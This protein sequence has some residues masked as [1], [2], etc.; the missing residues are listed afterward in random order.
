MRTFLIFS[1]LLV[2][3]IIFAP[4]IFA[5]VL[6]GI[7]ALTVSGLV[8]LTIVAA[9]MLLVGVIFGSTVLAL[10]AGA[11]TLLIVGFSVFWPLIVL[12]VVIWLCVRAGS[13]RTAL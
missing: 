3:G 12:F 9:V 7:I 5:S 11:A 10:I 13:T 4:G 6:G 2:V 1:V 8:G